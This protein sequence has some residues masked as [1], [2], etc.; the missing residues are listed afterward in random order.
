MRREGLEPLSPKI[1]AIQNVQFLAEV[2]TKLECHE[3]ETAVKI[4]IPG[5][6]RS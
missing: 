3:K 1:L 2:L 6:A 4:H 5:L